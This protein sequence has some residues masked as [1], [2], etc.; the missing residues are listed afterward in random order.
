MSI[1]RKNNKIYIVHKEAIENYEQFIERGNF[2]SSQEPQN[3]QEYENANLYSHIYINN[4]YL[5]CHYKSD[6]MDRLEKMISKCKT[7]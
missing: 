6:I 5:K 1:F 4:K 2:I 7:T 3:E